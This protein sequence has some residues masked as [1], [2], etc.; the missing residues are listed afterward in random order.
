MKCMFTQNECVC[1]YTDCNFYKIEDTSLT[2]N[3][4]VEEITNIISDT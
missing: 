1:W 2:I 3:N 4:Q